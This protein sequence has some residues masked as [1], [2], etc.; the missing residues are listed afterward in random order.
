MWDWDS[1]LDNKWARVAK[2]SQLLNIPI[3]MP[4]DTKEERRGTSWARATRELRR[5]RHRIEAD[6]GSKNQW[7]AGVWHM[8]MEQCGICYGRESRLS[9]RR[10]PTSLLQGTTQQSS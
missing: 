1:T 10:C 7:E 4:G 8:D 2:C 6:G 3:E 5:L 9:G